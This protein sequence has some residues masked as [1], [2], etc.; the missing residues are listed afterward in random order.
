MKDTRKEKYL[1]QRIK[2]GAEGEDTSVQFDLS[3]YKRTVFLHLQR[4]FNVRQGSCMS[5][6]SYGLPDFN[7]LDMKYGFSK[8]IKEIINAI[9]ENIER[10]EV[11]LKRIRVRFVKDE[12][13]PLDLSFEITGV[14]QVR[15]KSERIRFETK[16]SS[17]GT[18]EVK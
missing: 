18:L 9:K 13:R 16:R 4:M 6:P 3:A 8:A 15:G 17:S 10:N 14:L 12:T 1:M 7:D 2:D 5:N 11:G